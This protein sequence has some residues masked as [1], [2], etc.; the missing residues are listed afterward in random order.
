MQRDRPG[1]L[2]AQLAQSL[3]IALHDRRLIDPHALV[4]VELSQHRRGVAGVDQHL[5][6][7]Q[8]EVKVRRRHLADRAHLLVD[9][10]P[11]AGFD[12]VRGIA[13]RHGLL[14][15]RSERLRGHVDV[16]PRDRA[17]LTDLRQIEQPAN[18]DLERLAHQVI[19]GH[20]QACPQRVIP[21]VVRRVAP[22]DALDCFVR[23]ASPGV[24]EDRLAVA[25]DA[26]GIGRH[27]DHL[28]DPPLP[29]LARVPLLAT[30]RKGDIHDNPFHV[31]DLESG[32]HRFSPPRTGG[33]GTGPPRRTVLR[34]ESGPHAASALYVD[35][36]AESSGRTDFGILAM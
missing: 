18:R 30:R 35:R 12:L 31:S 8:V 13:P 33:A 17:P 16:P 19:E 27:T 34:S 3:H 1:G 21:Q 2:A 32:T 10:P 11:R 28:A 4:L 24:V 29:D 23:D 36:P 20:L 9:I 7:V 6:P 26:R 15:L 22:L 5:V 14:C 25:H